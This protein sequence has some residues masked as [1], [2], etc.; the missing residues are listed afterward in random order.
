MSDSNIPT[1]QQIIDDIT[2]NIEENLT[3]NSDPV[4]DSS[5]DDTGQSNETGIPED[6]DKSDSEE[7][8]K[9]VS[10]DFVDEE[11]LKDL[12]I[13]LSE[14]EKEQRHKKAL[15]LKVE[16]N[17]VFKQ[18]KLLEA[19][20]LYTEGLRICP[21]KFDS[22]RAVL[23]ANRGACKAKLDRKESAIE[24]CTKA[25]E[26]NSTYVRAYLRRAKL[27]EDSDKLDESLEDFKK[28]L[29]LDPG[30]KDALAATVRLPPKI[31]E[32]N[33]KLKEEMMGKLKDLGNVILR[34]F[35]LS[36]D[37]FKLTQD[38]NTGGYSVNFSQ[39]K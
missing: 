21:L 29:E 6:F 8:V 25:I 2:K 11:K 10:D 17:N 23:Y 9:E 1:N 39:N 33:E 16:G 14:E 36:T 19:I 12:E 5:K 27:Y 4:A 30:N 7:P 15:E 35:G 31:N 22:D 20:D 24:D 18:E 13:S 26:L 28:L 38:P 3:V 32:K 37:N 34:P